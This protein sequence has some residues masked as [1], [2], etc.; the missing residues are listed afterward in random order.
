MPYRYN[1]PRDPKP[2]CFALVGELITRWSWIDNQTTVILR[3]IL[4]L[5]KPESRMAIAGADAK[6]KIQ[7]INALADVVQTQGLG[8]PLREWCGRL[9][10]LATFR[11]RIA[12]SLW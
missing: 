9:D 2:D 1:I 3:E 5:T 4:R 7:I 10:S 12:H 6:V 8:T 11:N